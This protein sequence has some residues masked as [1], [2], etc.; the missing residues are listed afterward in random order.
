[1][2][3]GYGKTVFDRVNALETRDT[4]PSQH[5]FSEIVFIDKSNET[6]YQTRKDISTDLLI[7][8]PNY[9]SFPE[10]PF[11]LVGE[12]SAID[13]QKKVIFLKDNNTISYKYLITA[14]GLR[15]GLN[16]YQNDDFKRALQTLIDALRVQQ[17][18][19]PFDHNP[20]YEKSKQI[21][22]SMIR[23][24]KGASPKISAPTSQE[25]AQIQMPDGPLFEVHL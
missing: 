3:M 5:T 18:L 11:I 23:K 21:L 8:S 12:V 25:L 13:K 17:K 4:L 24:S 7:E 15:E 22:H 20:T 19:P 9:A 16:P 10:N 14:T 2:E 1:M 6:L